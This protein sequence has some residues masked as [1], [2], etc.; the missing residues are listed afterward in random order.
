MGHARALINI[1]EEKKQ[2]TITRRIIK[3]GLSVRQVEEIVKGKKEKE[4]ALKKGGKSD[5]SFSQQ[6]IKED[7]SD[8]LRADIQLQSNAK[9]KGKLVIP[10]ASEKDLE[11]ITELLGL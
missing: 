3:E 2:L 11:R 10:F 5:L 7:L 8:F 6:K 9:G 1:D 4:L